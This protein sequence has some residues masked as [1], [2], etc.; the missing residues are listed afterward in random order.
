[1]MKCSIHKTLT[2]F[3]AR[4]M[5]HVFIPS[6]T[7]KAILRFKISHTGQ[8]TL[9]LKMPQVFNNLPCHMQ[10]LSAWNLEFVMLFFIHI[11]LPI[12]RLEASSPMDGRWISAGYGYQF[13]VRFM[14]LLQLWSSHFSEIVIQFGVLSWLC[15]IL[16]S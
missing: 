10:M 14:P 11:L 13:V 5:T 1:M 6:M 16:V 15:F 12:S 4:D 9:R 2:I 8:E 3:Y 7:F